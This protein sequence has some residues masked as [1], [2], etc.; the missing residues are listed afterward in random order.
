MLN[1]TDPIRI[2]ADRTTEPP[3]DVNGD[4]PQDRSGGPALVYNDWDGGRAVIGSIEDE[5]HRCSSFDFSVAFITRGG[6]NFILQHLV[7]NAETVSGRIITTDYLNFSEPAAL[8]T[9]LRLPNVQTRVYTRG[10]FHTK[11]YIFHG[12]GET[13]LIIGSSNMTRDALSRNKEWNVR[14]SSNDP[15]CGL[16]T[17]TMDEFERMWA[18]SEVLTEQWIKEYEPSHVRARVGSARRVQDGQ[19]GSIVPNAMQGEALVNLAAF[20]NQGRGRALLVSA[21]GTGKTYLSA[22]DVR[23]S[24][25]R[26]LL[27]LVHREQI[28]RD[29]MESYRN[30]HGSGVSMGMVTGNRKD[31]G[32]DFIFSTTQSMS[33]RE[34]LERFAPDHFDYIVCDE[35]HH[36]ISPHYKRII[37]HFRP[38]FLLGMT[39]TPERMDSGDIFEIFDHNIAYEIRLQDALRQDML[40]PFHYYGVRDVTVDGE[41]LDDVSDFNLLVSEERVRHIIEKA[42]FYGYSGNRVKG[43]VFCRSKEEGR[44]ISSLMDA[45]GYRTMFICD[46]TRQSEREEAVCRLEQDDP[47]GALDYLVTVDIFNEGVDIKAV[48][49]LILLRPTQSATVFIQ[50]LGRGL[51]KLSASDGVKEYLVVIDFIGNYRNNFMIPMALSGD[52]SMSRENLRRVLM[53]NRNTIAGCS[54][55]DFDAVSRERIYSSINTTKGLTSMMKDEYR[56][57][58]KMLGYAPDLRYLRGTSK[59]DPVTLVARYGSLNG[60]RGKLRLPHLELVEEGETVLDYISSVAVRGMRPHEM[61]LLGNVIENGSMDLESLRVEIGAR[62]GIVTDDG[63]VDSCVRVLDGSF[64]DRLGEG[65]VTRDG[66]TVSITPFLDGLL[67][68]EGFREA[69]VDAL[70]CGLAVFRDRYLDGYD[71]VFTPFERYSR[72]DV[73]RLLNWNREG[74]SS[75]VYGY[76]VKGDMCPIFVTYRKGEDISRS[77]RYEDRFIDRSTF[78]W[79]TRSRVRIDGTEVTGI[80]RPTTGKYLFVQKGDDDSS[81]FYYMGRV[82]VVPDGVTQTTIEDDRG[83]MLPIVNILFRLREPVPEGIYDYIVN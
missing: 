69:V 65:L 39:A 74:E 72:A 79:M 3:I 36:S 46:E 71:G 76:R 2:R 77:T 81:D 66:D 9:L 33:R 37:D 44:E 14:V 52:T 50:Q 29:A 23:N 27:F 13:T 59:I 47:E 12:E 16:L 75:T 49:Q 21:T 30:I 70:E 19:P 40:C 11:G 68:K 56:N 45:N 42:E 54:T 15:E 4:G 57:L 7:N 5:L 1:D 51:R 22:F 83:R 62:F 26:R 80:M 31:W 55:V 78:S 60:F 64:S 34:N 67:R 32:A 61:V 43:L 10:S 73:C 18:D 24:G 28:L 82:D 35:A 41:T 48:N 25:A 58:V 20:R 17:Q 6:L 53:S 8:R 63:S 38:R